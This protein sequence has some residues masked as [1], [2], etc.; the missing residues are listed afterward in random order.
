MTF[1]CAL[2]SLMAPASAAV[3]GVVA[4]LLALGFHGWSRY[5]RRW[6]PIDEFDLELHQLRKQATVEHRGY[7]ANSLLGTSTYV[8]N[9]LFLPDA[10][11][12]R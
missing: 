4:P 3:A 1:F 5:G 6:H 9:F 12:P 11:P 7:V 2:K 10:T 8:N